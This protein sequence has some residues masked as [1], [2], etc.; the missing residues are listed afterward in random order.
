MITIIICF[1]NIA[2]ADRELP[3]E[4]PNE[5]KQMKS[6]KSLQKYL[7]NN[8]LQ[9]RI[10]AVKRLHEMNS[11]GSI[12]I[13]YE[14]YK[15]EPATDR[16]RIDRM[17]K[18][19][20]EVITALGDIHVDQSR[21]ILLKI[22]D[23]NIVRRPGYRRYPWEDKAYCSA[24]RAL[25][26]SLSK[27]EDEEIKQKLLKISNNLNIYFVLRA[28]AYKQ[29]LII[30]MKQQKLDTPSKQIPYLINLVKNQEDEWVS[31]FKDQNGPEA[32]QTMQTKVALEMLRHYDPTYLPIMEECYNK[33]SENMKTEQEEVKKVMDYINPTTDKITTP[34]Q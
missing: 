4:I 7:G 16:D 2:R 9:T 34:V 13:L 18:V 25:F 3:I 33:L 1:Q 12:D 17:G 27:W 22:L 6:E 20:E 11:S 19:Q 15:R 26:S 10:A 21:N 8:D 29:V 31:K 28:D 30:E 23:E 14:F 5:M 32:F 24:F